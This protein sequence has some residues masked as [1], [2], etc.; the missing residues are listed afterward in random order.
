M[1]LVASV[2]LSVATVLAPRLPS[3]P[4]ATRRVVEMATPVTAAPARQ[5]AP[6]RPTL[7]VAAVRAVLARPFNPLA[8]YPGAAS[9]RIQAVQYRA[10][11]PTS[12]IPTQNG[13]QATPSPMA[14][15]PATQT[16]TA[17]SRLHGTVPRL[18]GTM[19]RRGPGLLRLWNGAELVCSLRSC[20]EIMPIW[21]H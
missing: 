21:K 1:I 7:T 20:R 9:S 10:P 3:L 12:V 15:R 17:R 6:A 11:T 13:E 14:D 5:A 2:I 4:Q 16:P 18:H 19:P 8:D